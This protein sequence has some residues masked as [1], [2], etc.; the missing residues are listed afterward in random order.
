MIYGPIWTEV[1]DKE[2]SKSKLRNY[3]TFRINSQ[4]FRFYDT[5]IFH[6]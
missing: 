3:F 4:S 1:L 5:D 2:N 6:F